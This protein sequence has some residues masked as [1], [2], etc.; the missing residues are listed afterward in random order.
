[1]DFRE[2]RFLVC[3]FS[4]KSLCFYVFLRSFAATQTD[5]KNIKCSH[6]CFKTY[7]LQQ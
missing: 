1:M 3:F 4:M 6:N 5:A 7:A 2:E